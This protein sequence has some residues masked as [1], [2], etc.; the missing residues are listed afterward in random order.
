[1]EHNKGLYFF[2]VS[3]LVSYLRKLISCPGCIKFMDPKGEG[4]LCLTQKMQETSLVEHN[5]QKPDM[6]SKQNIYILKNTSN[7]QMSNKV[8][9]PGC[10][11]I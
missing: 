2:H 11:F 3:D 6:S 7:I 1:M 5:V 10:I 4:Y 9:Y 8:I